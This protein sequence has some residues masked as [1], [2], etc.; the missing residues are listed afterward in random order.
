[1]NTNPGHESKEQEYTNRPAAATFCTAETSLQGCSKYSV[2][3]EERNSF[4][5]LNS[6]K[7]GEMKHFANKH[8]S[9]AGT[10]LRVLY[11][12]SYPPA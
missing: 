6:W 3:Q 8:W 10:E 7:T 9:K 4:S 1:M 11:P 5:L 12:R 2:I